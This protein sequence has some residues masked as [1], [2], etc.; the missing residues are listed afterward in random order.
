[1]GSSF[2]LS[3]RIWISISILIFG[4]LCSLGAS[5]Y[6]SISIQRRLPDISE[7][8]V[9]STKLC[10]EI[11]R[12]FEQQ[13]KIYGKGVITGDP[14][15]I[16]EA[17]QQSVEVKKKLNQLKQLNGI[18]PALKQRI[19]NITRRLDQYTEDS[20]K[21]LTA[22]SGQEMVEQANRLANEKKMLSTELNEISSA[23]RQNL[24]E[25]VSDIIGHVRKS[26]SI[27]MLVSLSIIAVALIFVYWVIR[28]SI[29]GILYKITEKLYESSQNVAA[30]SS[31]IS[32]GS[33]QLSEGA[34][35]QAESVAQ[36]SGALGEIGAMTR[37]NAEDT[38]HAR[39]S[40]DE[41][42]AVVQQLGTYMDKLAQAM[43]SIK[44]RGEEIGK[45]IKTIDEISF[46]TNLLALNAAVEAAR[47]GEAG[48]GF[49]VVAGEVRNLAARS[50][51]AAKDTQGLIGK[52]VEEIQMGSRLLEDTKDAFSNTIAQNQKVG[53]VIDRIAES[54]QEQVRH[55]DE[56]NKT[57]S[58]ID[59]VVHR[60]VANAERFAS[61]FMNLN[62]QSERMSFFIRQL[63]GLNE[64]RREIRVR[65]ALR[66]HF[67]D[68]G[69]GRA[70]PFTT[71]DV[72]ASGASVLTPA[73][74]ESGALGEI[75]IRSGSI[76]LPFLE[77]RVV[78]ISDKPQDGKY[79]AGIQF[80]NVSDQVKDT[81]TDILSTDL[82]SGA[83]ED[84]S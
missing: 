20:H 61:V 21:T 15:V 68:A 75:E 59:Q 74:L 16:A 79:T 48:A 42:D 7:F 27:N 34:N 41:A 60:N 12:S 83:Y 31:E 14:E 13:N 58:E 57:M 9:S 37:Q 33:Q 3:I 84:F 17:R 70:E 71:R 8:A 23:V 76:Q 30:I 56:I 64:H 1:M 2:K 18:S 72:S 35:E 4:Y 80:I 39:K 65:I 29:V 45:I 46:Q 73:R 63:K 77:G 25:N 32:S 38:G 62:G 67:H 55:I 66:G 54:S 52:T 44:F 10:Q 22:S 53:Q 11:P 50:A 69:T 26:N 82:E 24:S 5:S 49:A 36:V 28:R 51:N 19:D 40:Q 6:M 47:A 43:S 78:R 81:I